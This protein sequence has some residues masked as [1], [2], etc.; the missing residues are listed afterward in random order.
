MRLDI[1][2]PQTRGAP[3]EDGYPNASIMTSRR[4]DTT[5]AMLRPSAVQYDLDSI[6]RVFSSFSPPDKGSFR[7]T[8]CLLNRAR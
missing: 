1:K 7:E 3:V 2:K 5:N 4:Y 8:C 6:T